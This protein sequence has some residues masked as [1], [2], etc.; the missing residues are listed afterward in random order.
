MAQREDHGTD[1]E[2]AAVGEFDVE[3]LR[4]RSRR[5]GE[6]LVEG[7]LDAV[8]QPFQQAR[9]RLA[10]VPSVQC[11]TGEVVRFESGQLRLLGVVQSH[12][13]TTT[14]LPPLIKRTTRE[15]RCELRVLGDERGIERLRVHQVQPGLLRLPHVTRTGRVR[16]HNFD[17]KGGPWLC[18]R[19][20]IR[21]QPLKDTGAPRA[22]PNQGNTFGLRF[23]HAQA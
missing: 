4:Y 19:S 15:R 23:S 9:Q 18:V 10:K 14:G 7:D 12:A 3:P 13:I 22:G 21:E 11:P 8:G 1:G 20:P 2:G 16:V 17:T 5:N 6:R